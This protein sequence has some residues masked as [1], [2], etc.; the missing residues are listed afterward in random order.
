M[1]RHEDYNFVN[2]VQIWQRILILIWAYLNI[3]TDSLFVYCLLFTV[4]LFVCLSVFYL[5]IRYKDNYTYVYKILSDKIVLIYYPH[6]K[7]VYICYTI[8]FV[9]QTFLLQT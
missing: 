5:F 4:C 2:I 1:V 3:V 7:H 8:H 9:L 6:S